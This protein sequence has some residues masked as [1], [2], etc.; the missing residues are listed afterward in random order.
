MGIQGTTIVLNAE[1]LRRTVPIWHALAGRSKPRGS[2]N[3]TSRG[4]GTKRGDRECDKN[5]ALSQFQKANGWIPSRGLFFLTNPRG[6][7]CSVVAR[8]PRRSNPGNSEAYSCYNTPQLHSDNKSNPGL[9]R[10]FVEDSSFLATTRRDPCPILPSPPLRSP[11]DLQALRGVWSRL[12]ARQH[13]LLRAHRGDW[14]RDCTP[15]RDGAGAD[16]PIPRRLA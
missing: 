7:S 13:L 15:R 11:Q 5:V 1:M 16:S 12:W 3:A 8:S 10:H 14:T 4:S 2:G 6:C 9:P